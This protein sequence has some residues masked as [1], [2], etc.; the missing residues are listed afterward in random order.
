MDTP[1]RVASPEGPCVGELAQPT[2]G[3][4]ETYTQLLE[5][6]TAREDVDIDRPRTQATA[7]PVSSSSSS[8]T[9]WTRADPKTDPPRS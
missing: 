2:L 8:N 5:D 7:S 1:T 4:E 9:S 3:D 6:S